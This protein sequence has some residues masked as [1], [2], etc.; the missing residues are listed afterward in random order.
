MRI[1]GMAEHFII[2]LQLIITALITAEK[3][4]LL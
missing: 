3:M 1:V 2:G 4:A